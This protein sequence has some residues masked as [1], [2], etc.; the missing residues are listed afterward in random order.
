MSDWSGRYQWQSGFPWLRPRPNSRRSS[1]RC[2][3]AMRT[4]WSSAGAG[5]S[6]RSYASRN[7]NRSSHG[8]TLPDGRRA[9][10]P[11]P[12]P[13]AAQVEGALGAHLERRGTPIGDAGV[14]I[15]A[16]ALANGLTVVTGN[17]RHFERVPGLHVENWLA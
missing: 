15:A 11:S 16:I 3:T 4:T 8:T 14:R 6:P 7:S 1:T 5:R 10:S 9:H 12:D 2:C 17:V 13:R